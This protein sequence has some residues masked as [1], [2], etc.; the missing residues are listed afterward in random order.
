MADCP[1]PR[2]VPL[3]DPDLARLVETWPRLP[4]AIRRGILAM[5][6]AAAPNG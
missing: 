2:T 6:E 3:T 4:D 5:I 1:N